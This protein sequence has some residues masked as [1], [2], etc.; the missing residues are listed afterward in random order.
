[1]IK[2]IKRTFLTFLAAGMALMCVLFTACTPEEDYG[3]PATDGYQVTFLYPDGSPVKGTDYAGSGQKA[4]KTYAVLQDANGNNLTQPAQGVLNDYGTVNFNYKVPGEYTVYLGN[5]PDGYSYETFKTTA[6]RARYSVN[7]TLN[8]TKYEINVQNPDGSAYTNANVK[9]MNGDNEIAS[10]T[11]DAQGKATSQSVIAGEYDIFVDIPDTLGYR[12]VKTTKKG[13]PST[14]KLFNV[15]LI[16][17]SDE[18]IMSEEE[19]DSWASDRNLNNDLFTKVNTSVDN[20]LYNA[21]IKGS[22]EKFFLIKA[23]WSGSYSITAR[24][25]RD[26]GGNIQKDANYNMHFYGSTFDPE[27]ERKDLNILGSTNGGNNMQNISLKA[28]EKFIISVS[29]LNSED[30]IFPFIISYDREP[31]TVSASESKDYTLKFD[32]INYAI[33]EFKPTVSGKFEITSTSLEYDPMLVCYSSATKKPLPL[34]KNETSDLTDERFIGCAG[35]DNGGEGNNF[36]YT[37][38]VMKNFVGNTYFYY[39]YLKDSNINYPAE[40]NVKITRTGDATEETV[41]QKKIATATAAWETQDEQ[42]GK[43]FRF[44]P[45]DGSATV[46]EKNGGYY[47][48]VDGSEYELHAAI[49]LELQSSFDGNSYKEGIGYSYATIE[50]MGDSSVSPASEDNTEQKNTNLTV[51]EDLNKRDVTW[52]YTQ[53][54]KDYASHCNSVGTYKLNAELK[55]FMERYNNQRGLE[56]IWY[57]EIENAKPEYYWLLGCGYYA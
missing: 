24:S 45:I 43:S 52:N 48:T 8:Y 28:G 4:P 19:L 22:E 51:Y 56:I 10:L 16:D 14:I 2:I 21:D 35:N 20:Y 13:S 36:L 37:E 33:I 17:F 50:Y 32:Q 55:L 46:A 3:D 18:D 6:D 25:D 38:D 54:I 49:S 57:M 53:F 27:L 31:H 34:G 41:V 1:M 11:T 23:K 9:L 15:S 30:Y 29:S 12:P 5:V 26:A 39:I 44:A 7:L 47:I 40:I 42:T